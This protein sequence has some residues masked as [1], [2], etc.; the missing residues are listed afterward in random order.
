MGFLPQFPGCVISL[1]CGEAERIIV[2]EAKILQPLLEPQQVVDMREQGLVKSR[3]VLGREIVA[4]H[5]T[6][7]AGRVAQFQESQPMCGRFTLRTPASVL[8]RQ[9]A[10]DAG[11][12]LPLRYDIAPTQLVSVRASLN[13]S[14]AFIMI[15]FID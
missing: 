12:Q 15:K 4:R 2:G 7:L 9:Y 5:V 3:G 10:V 6:N 8:I 11:L 13:S 14:T 1:R